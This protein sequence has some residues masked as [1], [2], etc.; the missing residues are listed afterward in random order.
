MCFTPSVNIKCVAF[1]SS[2]SLSLKVS[3]TYVLQDEL[4]AR[5]ARHYV[6]PEPPHLCFNEG[7]NRVCHAYTSYS[8]SIPVNASFR[9][10]KNARTRREW[11]A[12]PIAEDIRCRIP[13]ELEASVAEFNQS[14]TVE[15]DL[16]DPFM[17]PG[18]RVLTKNE[19]GIKTVFSIKKQNECGN[20]GL[21]EGS[22][23]DLNFV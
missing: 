11:C 23:S 16:L 13:R 12:Y 19:N 5:K 1:F 3:I 2:V 10:A 9:E 20:R 7:D 15:C 8:G 4:K 6:I 14:C 22:L 17:L 18:T 21:H